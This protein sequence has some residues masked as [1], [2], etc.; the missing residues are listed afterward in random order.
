MMMLML[1]EEEEKITLSDRNRIE[2]QRKE[3]IRL[4]SA[5]TNTRIPSTWIDR[6]TIHQRK[7]NV[8]KLKDDDDELDEGQKET[9]VCFFFFVYY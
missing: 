2:R 7:K 1:V 4:L 6:H 3:K 5:R 9:N 8:C